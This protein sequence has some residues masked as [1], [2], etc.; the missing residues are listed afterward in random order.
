MEKVLARRAMF[1]VAVAVLCASCSGQR[2][3]LSEDVAAASEVVPEGLAVSTTV[4]EP[5][6]VPLTTIGE[7]DVVPGT[8]V[9][10]D[11]RQNAVLGVATADA[12]DV[13][14]QIDV[15]IGGTARCGLVEFTGID[16]IGSVID[17]QVKTDGGAP[18]DETVFLQLL[19]L[20]PQAGTYD[21]FVNGTLVGAQFEID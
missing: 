9:P 3:T 6:V 12:A 14:G 1:F 15:M 18:C 10:A 8:T 16:A 19:Q 13:A 17:L 5:D 20:T 4:A 21:I 7:L 11:P 2:P